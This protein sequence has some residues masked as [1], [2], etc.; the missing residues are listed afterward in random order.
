[1]S[2]CLLVMDAQESFRHCEFF[3]ELITDDIVARTTVA[4]RDR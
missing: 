3:S 2:A 1:M 4:L